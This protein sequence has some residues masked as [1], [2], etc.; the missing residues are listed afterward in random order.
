MSKAVTTSRRDIHRQTNTCSDAIAPA[1]K[2]PLRLAQ[3]R[4]CDCKRSHLERA[5]S[6]MRTRDKVVEK[7]L[8][9]SKNG[10]KE[11]AVDHKGAFKIHPAA[12]AEV[13]CHPTP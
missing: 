11:Q 3:G 8:K 9:E 12:R 1:L 2:R 7:K 13:G 5:Q 4:F 10:E 6:K